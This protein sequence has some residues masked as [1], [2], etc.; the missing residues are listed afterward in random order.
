MDGISEIGMTEERR[1]EDARALP[2]ETDKVSASG[3][4]IK[5]AFWNKRG[6]YVQE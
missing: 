2:L 4:L 1:C 6:N 5:K 3:G